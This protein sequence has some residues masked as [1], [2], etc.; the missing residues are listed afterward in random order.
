MEVAQNIASLFRLFV[1]QSCN[2]EK[3]LRERLELV[4]FERRLS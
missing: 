2:G 1:S 4:T 3:K